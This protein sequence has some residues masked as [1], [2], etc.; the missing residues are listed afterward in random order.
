MRPLVLSTLLTILA[1][2]AF[3]EERQAN[4][5]VSGLTCPSCSFIAGRSIDALD[6]AQ[7][8]DFAPAGQSTGR[9]TVV[10]DDARVT[11]AAIEAAVEANGYE[12]NLAGAGS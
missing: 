11:P 12:A 3:A 5:D 1:A 7:V 6:G 8:L 10:Y 9:F 2:P 4:L